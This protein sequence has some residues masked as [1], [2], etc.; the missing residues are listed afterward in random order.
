MGV[1]GFGLGAYVWTAVGKSLLDPA[2]RYAWL[3]WQVQAAFAV[4]FAVI[5]AAV[6]PFMRSP[7]PGWQPPPHPDDDV[8]PSASDNTAAW[9]TRAWRWVQRA[10]RRAMTQRG[11]VR[12][13]L[14]RPYTFLQAASQLEFLLLAVIIFGISAPGICFLS[15]AADMV[16]NTFGLDAG[17]AGTI[18]S[19]LN[20][21]NFTGRFGWGLATDRLGRKS[22]FLLSTSAQAVAVG[23]M[24]PFIT[25]RAFGAWLAA[26]LLIGSLYGGSFGVL[27]AMVSDLWGPRISAATHGAMIAVWALASLVGINTF[28]AIT[29]A[30]AVVVDGVRVPQPAAYV[31]N[32]EWLVWPPAVGFLAALLLT[33]H[34]RDRILRKR[35]HH[36][37]IRLCG[38][39]CTVRC[40]LLG[41]AAQEEEWRLY[42]N[43][44][45]GVGGTD[46]PV[47][48]PAPPSPIADAVANPIIHK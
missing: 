25:A 19:L 28:T 1:F 3:P 43:D 39:V 33:V 6:L 45:G 7:P 31:L 30:N 11:H 16:Q 2:G 26:F 10:G 18:T 29:A 44:G 13:A 48:T 36:L 8:A 4:T 12:P 14:D 40:A 47:D 20:L 17:T 35:L 38:A 27:P 24:G 41:R 15:S 46:A 21:T 22:Y 5:L 32:A 42:G 23:L 37:R 34:P 9:Y